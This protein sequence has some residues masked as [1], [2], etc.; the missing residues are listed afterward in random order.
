MGASIE[1]IPKRVQLDG[2]AD[3]VEQLRMMA[4]AQQRSQQILIE[5]IN[6]IVD[7]IAE[8]ELKSTDVAP[9]VEAVRSLKQEVVTESNT[10]DYQ[11]SGKRDERT[12]LI[13]LNTV[14]FSVVK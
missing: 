10:P 8:K 12:G 3:V 11:L 4:E 9:L 1:S 5:S 14:R 7:A 2:L 6:G 13:D